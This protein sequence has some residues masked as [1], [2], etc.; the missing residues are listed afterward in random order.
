VN[1]GTLTI[2]PG[3]SI[4]SASLLSITPG[5]VVNLSQSAWNAFGASQQS[6]TWTIAG[7]LRATTAQA[8]TVVA[9]V[10]LNN[11]TMDSTGGAPTGYGA[12][13]VNGKTITANG[14]A[15]SISGNGQVGVTGTVTLDTPL[16]TDA[17]S[18]SAAVGATSAQSGGLTKKGLGTVT[19]SGVNIYTGATTVSNGTLLVTGSLAG[20]S[21]VTVA[22]GTLGGTGSIAGAVNVQI[23]GTL[24]PGASIGTL[25]ISNTLTLA[26]TTLVE[27]NASNGQSD[28]VQGATNIVYGG[29]LV[30][31]NVAGT[32]VLGQNFQLFSASGTKTGDFTSITP[33]LTG[34][35][36]WSFNPTNGVLSVVTATANYPTNISYSLSGGTLTL[37]WPVTHLGWI[38]QSNAVSVA[39]SNTWFDIP[40]S[41][42]GTSLNLIPSP[43]WTNVFY[44]LR[45]P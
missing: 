1:Q 11:G 30:V 44:R 23:G 39:S 27:V 31:T 34:G 42:G 4:N 3:G 45:A 18:I 17:L 7:T 32:L 22:G 5:A 40:G 16:A 38:A 13:Y 35:K 43:G 15:N 29:T 10:A 37:T 14:A 25:S 8:N 41:S 6:G 21:A 24:S 28:R 2:G 26:G 20:G 12:F 33:A 36:A 9:H 19:L